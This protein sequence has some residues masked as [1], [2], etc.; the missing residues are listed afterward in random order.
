MIE[1]ERV[2]RYL[3]A[4]ELRQSGLTLKD[5]GK[6]L[7]VSSER[8]R[9]MCNQYKRESQLERGWQDKFSTLLSNTLKSL[10]LTE[11]EVRKQVQDGTISKHMGIGKSF[12]KEL[13]E[14]YL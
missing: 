2:D 4:Y 13:S 10:R 9:Q 3:K 12:V 6:H 11:D 8:V 7:G 5:V 14:F 1:S